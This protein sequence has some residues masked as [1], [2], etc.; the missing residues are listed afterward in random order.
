MSA[1]ATQGGHKERRRRKI[2]NTGQKYN[3][4]NNWLPG[5]PEPS[6]TAYRECS[7]YN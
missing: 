1:S 3:G 2:E 6:V 7:F 4:K 5:C